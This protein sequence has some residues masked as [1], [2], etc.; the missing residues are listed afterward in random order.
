MRRA[1]LVLLLLLAGCGRAPKQDSHAAAVAVPAPAAAS[2]SAPD[3]EV[4]GNDWVTGEPTAD[5]PSI[6]AVRDT[7]AGILWARLTPGDTALHLSTERGGFKYWYAADSAA[8]WVVRYVVNDTTACPVEMIEHAL[9]KSGWTYA[10]GYSADGPD[11]TVLGLKSRKFLCVIE[12]RWE[13]G[14]DS[15]STYVPKPGC[16]LTATVVPRNPKD[17]FANK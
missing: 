11:G 4:P 13:G 2:A 15:D 9:F 14:D 5:P 12:G 8:G 1:A 3:V 7:I 16:V 10:D 6:E 17:V